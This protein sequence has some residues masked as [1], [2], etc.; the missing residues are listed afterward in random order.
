MNYKIG[1]TI[2]FIGNNVGDKHYDNFQIGTQYKIIEIGTAYDA[3]QYNSDS[4]Y[5]IFAD[6]NC[7]ALYSNLNR[8]FVHLEDWRDG[9][10]DSIL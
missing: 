8:C 9:K 3:D 4:R 10:I 5:V 1:D 2:V 6:S 7:G